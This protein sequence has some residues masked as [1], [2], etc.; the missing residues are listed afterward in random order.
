M[1]ITPLAA[2]LALALL[3]SCVSSPPAGPSVPAYTPPPPAIYS[4]PVRHE[5]EDDDIETAENVPASA[6]GGLGGPLTNL[7]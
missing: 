6:P 7:S 4:P 3:A 2:V 1:K 5:P